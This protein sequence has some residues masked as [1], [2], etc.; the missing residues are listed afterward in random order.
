MTANTRIADHAIH[1][2]FTQRWSPRAFTD[3]T[4]DTPTLMSFL[5]PHAGRL[6]LTTRSLGAFC[7]RCAAPRRLIAT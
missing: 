5:K 2:Q 6:Q 4:L 7:S 3:A 1:E